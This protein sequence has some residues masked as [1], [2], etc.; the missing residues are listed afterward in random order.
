[1]NGIGYG[2]CLTCYETKIDY[3]GSNEKGN[4]YG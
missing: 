1:M 3:G 4:C 2:G